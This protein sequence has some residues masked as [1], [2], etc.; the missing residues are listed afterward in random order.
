[1]NFGDAL[2][3]AISFF[4]LF[5]SF[6]F[7]LI[8]FENRKSLVLGETKVFP[9]VAIIVPC[10][11][12]ENTVAKTLKSLLNLDY[13]KDKLEI[14][15]VDD[16]STDNT[17]K[18]VSEFIKEN[19][20]KNIK[21]YTKKNGGKY[22]ALNLALKKTNAEFVG[23]LDADSFVDSQALKRI[24]PYFHKRTVVAVT[25][26]MKIYSPKTFLQKVQSIEYMMGIFLRKVFAELG[27]IHV[28]PGPFSIYRKSFFERHGYY[29]EAYH[30]EDIEVALR[31]QKNNYVIENSIDSYVYTV[32]PTNFKVLYKQRLRWYYGFINN[33]ID[34]KELFSRKHGNLGLF[35]LP[36][37]FIS[38]LFVIISLFYVIIKQFDSMIT[39]FQNLMAVH[40]DVFKLKWFTWDLFFVNTNAVAIISL[41]TFFLGVF[42]IFISKKVSG[43]KN[44][45][46]FS[47]ILYML[48][49]WFLFGFWWFMALI[50]IIFKKKTVWGHKSE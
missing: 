8:L 45:V 28:T 14:I 37:S 20:A 7:L 42:I 24:I 38:I 2:V 50:Y 41:V 27:S 26:S 44:S 43:E 23:A 29:R 12:E 36:S 49:Y 35:I 34:Y 4:G 19:S 25:P 5:T 46:S 17:S 48:V 18:V 3:Y 9:T 39:H 21:I 40:F 11:N 47:Y 22:T 13:P 1:M 10:Y 32:G 31:I 30:T 15:V 6:Y 16:G 33:V